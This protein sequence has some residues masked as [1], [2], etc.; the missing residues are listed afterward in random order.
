MPH[1][2]QHGQALQALTVSQM[3]DRLLQLPEGT[4]LM[5]LAPVVSGRK[6]EFAELLV[7]LQAQGFVRFRIDGQIVQ[8]ADLPTLDKTPAPRIAVV[9]DRL[10]VRPDIAQRLAESLEAALRLAP[11]AGRIEV[12]DMD[13]G[14]LLTL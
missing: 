10:K 3:V 13:S 12:Q 4:R 14:Q 6:G 11:E 5:L 2:P 8:A 1:C 9:V 7:Q